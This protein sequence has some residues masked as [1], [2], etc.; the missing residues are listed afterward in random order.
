MRKK[1]PRLA[2]PDEVTIS[3][4]GDT[5]IIEFHDPAIATTHF[6][7]GPGLNEMSDAQVLEQFN[8]FI[9]DRDIRAAQYKYV[10]VEIPEGKP[11]IEYHEDSDQWT[12]RGHVLRCF[13]EDGGPDFEA[14]LHVDEHEISL[15]EFGRLLTAYAGWGMRIV[16]VPDEN[17]SKDP[18]VEV[19]DSK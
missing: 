8:Q 16:F 6:E 10:A 18:V 7:I 17:L 5:A 1:K 14:T 4:D 19:R 15:Q 11:Q 3:R 12:T 9:V 2:Q 13:I